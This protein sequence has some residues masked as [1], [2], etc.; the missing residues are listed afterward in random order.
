MK[1]IV[2]IALSIAMALSLFSIEIVAEDY[3]DTEYW[4]GVCYGEDKMDHASECL[5][6][7][8]NRTNAIKDEIDAAKEDLEE[9]QD[10][11]NSYRTQIDALEEKIE[12][13]QVQIDELNARI[14]ELEI[15]IEDN[16]KRVDELNQVVLDRMASKQTIMHFDSFVEFILGSTS[17]DDMLR[18]SYGLNTIMGSDEDTRI[19]IEGIIEKLNEDQ[20]EIEESKKKIEA[21]VAT[22]EA[23]QA[24]LETMEEFYNDVAIRSQE[25]IQQLQ[26][27]QD[28]AFDISNEIMESINDIEDVPTSSGLMAPVSGA[29]I[30]QG[31]PYYSSGGY[32]LGVDYAVPIGTPLKAPANGIIINTANGCSTWGGLGN[33]CGGQF[34]GVSG[35]GNQITMIMAADGVVYGMTVF[36]LE[37]NSIIVSEGEIVM[38]GQ[39]LAST[40]SSG[41]STGPHAH[42]EVYLLG[43]G[44]VSDL[45]DYLS[46]GYSLSFNCGWGWSGLDRLCANGVGAPCRI[47]G[48]VFWS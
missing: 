36:H 5:E 10:L 11:A 38:Q 21:N 8:Q 1:K 13:L 41:S 42:I 26:N 9:A 39:Q 18:R 47:D 2:K 31:M 14:E 25:I 6:Y 44:E 33:T 19:E 30:S 35:G 20:E 23:N 16:E 32:H 37:L 34:G 45:D 24:E 29:W 7:F 15:Q 28:H 22:L 48:R 17:F 43:P 46:R 27:E 12:G 40:G 3:S 4:D